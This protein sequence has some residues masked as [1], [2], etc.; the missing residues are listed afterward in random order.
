[1]AGSVLCRHGMAL[2]RLI[3]PQ[4]SSIRKLLTRIAVTVTVTLA[5]FAPQA[6]AQTPAKANALGQLREWRQRLLTEDEKSVKLQ[7][8]IVT[9]VSKTRTDADADRAIEAK[10]GEIAVI[11]DERVEIEARRRIVDQLTFSVDTKWS[12]TDLKSFLEGQLLDLAI[13]DLSEPGHGG[14]WKFLIKSS[15][16]LREHAEPGADPV[17]FLEAFMAES[18][19]L[20]PKPISDVIQSRT[21][22]R[23]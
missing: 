11:D 4:T 10:L 1:M 23:R 9:A 13:T 3:D 15:I 12:G 20:E 6:Q 5:V 8:D 16:A 2:P 7:K 17:R 22:I 18:S 19:V 14:W 21:Y